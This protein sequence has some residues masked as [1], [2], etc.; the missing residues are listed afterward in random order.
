MKGLNTQGFKWEG[1]P[2][3]EENLP[4]DMKILLNNNLSDFMTAMMKDRVP[5]FR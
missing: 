1:N 4:D 5:Y 3:V 2:K